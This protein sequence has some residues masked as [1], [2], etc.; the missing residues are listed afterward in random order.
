MLPAPLAREKQRLRDRSPS[1]S[2]RERLIAETGLQNIRLITELYCPILPHFLWFSIARKLQ[3]AFT[4][5]A[6]HVAAGL[7]DCQIAGMLQKHDSW[8]KFS[9]CTCIWAQTKSLILNTRM[10]K[11][12]IIPTDYFA[13]WDFCLVQRF[14]TDFTHSFSVIELD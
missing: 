6:H 10:L 13:S 14:T 9:Y 5:A 4:D 7:G 2:H 3:W 1:P 8:Y 11:S 12:N